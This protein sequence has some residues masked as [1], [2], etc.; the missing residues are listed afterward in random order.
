MTVDEMRLA[1]VTV[2][3]ALALVP[4]A[5]AGPLRPDPV[6]VGVGA[7]EFSLS[8]YRPAVKAGSAVRFNLTN[9]GE[10]GHD[11]AVLTPKGTVAGRIDE[12][13]GFGGRG[14]VEVRLRRKGRY[15][16][17]CTVAGHAKLG[18]R[19]RLRVR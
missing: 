12:V 8:L 16:L 13:R 4:A 7:R 17:L 3:L 2:L 6:A 1:L 18:M 9:F 14:Q 11:L 15:T 5:Q 10:D 19:A